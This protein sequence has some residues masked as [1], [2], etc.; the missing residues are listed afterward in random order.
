MRIE[1]TVGLFGGYL[2]FGWGGA[3]MVGCSV[4]GFIESELSECADRVLAGGESDFVVA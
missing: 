1:L 4:V 3:E 2:E